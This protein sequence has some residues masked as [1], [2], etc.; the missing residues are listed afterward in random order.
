[1]ALDPDGL[2]RGGLTRHTAR[3]IAA[4]A[5]AALPRF[6]HAPPALALPPLGDAG[7]G[8]LA[9]VFGGAVA[10]GSDVAGRHSPGILGFSGKP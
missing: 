7:R 3:R 6:P 2:L 10:F 5:G 9:G 1:M 4:A 8:G